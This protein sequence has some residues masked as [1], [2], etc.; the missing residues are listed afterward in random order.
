MTVVSCTGA[1]FFKAFE[2]QIQQLLIVVIG[3]WLIYEINIYCVGVHVVYI[4]LINC[5]VIGICYAFYRKL[6]VAST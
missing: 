4:I 6:S 2:M 5:T 1:H 3:A